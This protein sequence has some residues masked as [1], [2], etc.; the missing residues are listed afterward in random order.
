MG[1]EP[2]RAQRTDARGLRRLGRRL[3]HGLPT[4]GRYTLV[5]DT[6]LRPRVPSSGRRRLDK[7]PGVVSAAALAFFRTWIDRP[8]SPPTDPQGRTLPV[9]ISGSQDGV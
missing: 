6:R 4:P 5:V 8:M 7:L 9:A 3:G 1:V 2:T